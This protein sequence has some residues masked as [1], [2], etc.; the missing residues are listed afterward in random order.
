[1]FTNRVLLH[2]SIV[3]RIEVRPV[4]RLPQRGRSR[5]AHPLYRSGTRMARSGERDG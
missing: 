4:A 3:D 1:M 5:R 2:E